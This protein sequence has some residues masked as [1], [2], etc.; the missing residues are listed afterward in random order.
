MTATQIAAN[1]TATV[2]ANQTAQANATATAQ[3]NQTLTPP[4]SGGSAPIIGPNPVPKGGSLC[5][6][7]DKPILGGQWDLFN[8]VGE[9][10]GGIALTGSATNCMNLGSLGIAPGLYLA[11]LDLRYADGTTQITWKKVVVTP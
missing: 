11:R 7:P 2:L 10:L 1:A 3:A 8:F 4:V 5:L 6:Y 9:N